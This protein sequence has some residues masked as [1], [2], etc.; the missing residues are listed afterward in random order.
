MDITFTETLRPE[1]I[2][3]GWADL[4]GYISDVEWRKHRA[5]VNLDLIGPGSIKEAS[6]CW[7]RRFDETVFR[8]S[9]RPN[10][11]QAL[12][13]AWGQTT[14]KYVLHLEMDW[15]LSRS[16]SVDCLILEMNRL[17]YDAVNLRAYGDDVK[18]R[19]C[20]S[21][22]IIRGDVC[23]RLASELNTDANPEAQFRDPSF[24]EGG[25]GLATNIRSLHWPTYPILQD[26]GA[27]W[28]KENGYRLPGHN[29]LTWT[30]R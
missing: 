14:S 13:W 19:L 24:R 9:W 10:F 12:K 2:E 3:Q 5:I 26:T 6:A 28:R 29:F 1:L 25:R 11:A 20:L 23:R 15:A 7:T 27:A 22:C 30:K 17:G 16:V 21:P 8:M 18:E 4:C